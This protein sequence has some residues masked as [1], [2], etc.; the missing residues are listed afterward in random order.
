MMRHTPIAV[1]TLA[2]TLSGCGEAALPT[3]VVAATKLTASSDAPNDENGPVRTI[4]HQVPHVST[5]A[6]NAGELGQV[7]LRERVRTDSE[8]HL[9]TAGRR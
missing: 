6:A 9:R 8:Q 1:W 3:H 5:V 4:D 7:F 2:L